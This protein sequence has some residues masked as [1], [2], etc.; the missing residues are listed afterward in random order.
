MPQS[1]KFPL[2]ST[3][4]SAAVDSHVNSRSSHAKPGD[5]GGGGVGGGGAYQRSSLPPGFRPLGHLQPPTTH[6][7]S[8]Y[9]YTSPLQRTLTPPA[10]NPAAGP[11][12]PE[13]FPTIESIESSGSGTNFH[14]PRSGLPTSAS[15]NENTS[16]LQFH[17]QPYQHSQTSSF[18]SRAEL[19]EIY[20]ANCGRPKKLNSTF[21]CTECICGVCNDCVASII[22]S[23]VISIQPGQAPI[24]RGCPR[25]G[26]MGGKW[27]RIQ[28]DFR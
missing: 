1:P 12:D 16:P 13:P 17:R 8:P 26:A 23:P 5:G 22:N 19:L 21:A 11:N 7:P 6:Q 15:S 25:C 14:I 18:G 4:Q 2:A 28:L 24:R 9:T 10:P 27:K 3:S 20:C